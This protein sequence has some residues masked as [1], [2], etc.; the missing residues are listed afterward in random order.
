M[1]YEFCMRF[2]LA[3][4]GVCMKYWPLYEFCIFGPITTL[5]TTTVFKTA[6]LKC[7]DGAPLSRIK[8]HLFESYQEDG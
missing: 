7:L 1:K 6:T 5:Y 2:E 8:Y 3:L 4:N